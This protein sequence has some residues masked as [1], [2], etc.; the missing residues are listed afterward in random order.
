MRKRTITIILIFLSTVAV[1]LCFALSCQTTPASSADA[2]QPEIRLSSEFFNPDHESL[3]IYLPPILDM[4][5]VL[6]WRV[7][8]LEPLPSYLV[9]Q[10]WVGKGQPPPHIIWNGRNSGGKQVHSA[11]DYPL[12]YYVSD[13][14]GNIRTIET[15]IKVGFVLVSNM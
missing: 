2:T 6:S 8:V 9:F 5:Q 3:T 4:T 10:N 11:K 15:K 1:I 13:V 7:E 12:V 14:D